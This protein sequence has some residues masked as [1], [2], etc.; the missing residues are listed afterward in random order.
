[1]IPIEHAKEFFQAL[2]KG[3]TSNGHE[4]TDEIIDSLTEKLCSQNCIVCGE[5]AQVPGV[6]MPSEDSILMARR[7]AAGGRLIF[8]AACSKHVGQDW[9]DEIETNLIK[10][11][12]KR[13][14]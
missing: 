2:T 7:M 13:L 5:E 4:F 9:T 3:E 8:Y 10:R 1:M 11:M 6:H 12:K 14:H